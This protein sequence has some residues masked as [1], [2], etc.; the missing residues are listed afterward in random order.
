MQEDTSTRHLRDGKGGRVC[1]DS[2]GCREGA[3]ARDGRARN[4]QRQ[5][6]LVGWV[7]TGQAWTR[8]KTGVRTA[9]LGA[10]GQGAES[11]RARARARARGRGRARA[12]ARA[13]AT[14]LPQ[15]NRPAQQAGARDPGVSRAL[16]G[17]LQCRTQQCARTAW[18]L[19]FSDN[20]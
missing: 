16:P 13:R 3:K 10:K 15:Q 7:E 12:R 4:R 9:W 19:G 17:G 6:G 5:R 8:H 2:L 14:T 11:A 1:E 20:C 18:G